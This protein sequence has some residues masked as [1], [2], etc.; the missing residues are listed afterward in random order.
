MR[1][2][3]LSYLIY[4]T[5]THLVMPHATEEFYRQQKLVKVEVKKQSLMA[6]AL[7]STRPPH[8]TVWGACKS[9]SSYMATLLQA[10]SSRGLA[11]YWETSYEAFPTK[12]LFQNSFLFS[13]HVQE[14]NVS[15]VKEKDFYQLFFFSLFMQYICTTS[16]WNGKAHE[17]QKG[18]IKMQASRIMHSFKKKKRKNV[19]I[20]GRSCWKCMC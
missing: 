6:T 17:N 8:C 3:C 14:K 7:Q 9:G 18:W 12:C 15:K 20:C 19:R 16:P 5:F 11:E 1:G 13:F 4:I 10:S 2:K